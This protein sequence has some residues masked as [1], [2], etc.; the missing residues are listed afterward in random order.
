MQAH[1]CSQGDIYWLLNFK[2]KHYLTYQL[3]IGQ[4]VLGKSCQK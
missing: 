1:F 2:M 4:T 3:K